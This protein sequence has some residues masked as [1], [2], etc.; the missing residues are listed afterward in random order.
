MTLSMSNQYF[1]GNLSTLDT[2]DDAHS[3]AEA[4]KI[5]DAIFAK[6]GRP[7]VGYLAVPVTWAA[8]FGRTR[9]NLFD[10]CVNI[11]IATAMLSEYDHACSARPDHQPRSKRQHRRRSH[12]VASHA[13]RYCILRRL[14]IDLDITGVAEHVLPK[15]AKLDAKPQDPDL[16]PPPARSPA[17]PDDT[18]SSRVHETSDWS[19]PRLYLPFPPTDP[20]SSPPASPTPETGSSLKSSL[21]PRSASSLPFKRP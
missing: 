4:H 18:D 17:F 8:R 15:I 19:S 16:D 6:G 3:V 21:P 10:G 1:V 11:G 7:A 5:V 2:Y 14:E 20:I 13:L 12:P 9:D